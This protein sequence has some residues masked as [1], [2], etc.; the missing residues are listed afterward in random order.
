MKQAHKTPPMV[1]SVCVDV[2]NMMLR[3]GLDTCNYTKGI[4]ETNS[5][6]LYRRLRG[7]GSPLPIVGLILEEGHTSQ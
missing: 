2:K 5:T 7:H 1:F 4:Q 6:H 3:S